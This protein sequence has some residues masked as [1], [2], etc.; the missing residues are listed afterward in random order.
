MIVIKNKVTNKIMLKADYFLK[1]YRSSKK[2]FKILGFETVSDIIKGSRKAELVE[3]ERENLELIARKYK[4]I[5]RRKA[6]IKE[7][8]KL[9]EKYK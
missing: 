8:E 5:L 3:I 1:Y 6:V 4:E 7:I 2:D 9:K